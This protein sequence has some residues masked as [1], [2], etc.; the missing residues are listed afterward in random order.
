MRRKQFLTNN[1]IY[2]II[3]S[4]LVLL[5]AIF[6]NKIKEPFQTPI[7]GLTTYTASL[8]VPIRP[9]SCPYIYNLPVVSG[10]PT[11]YTINTTTLHSINNRALGFSVEFDIAHKIF[12]YKNGSVRASFISLMNL[13]K[14]TQNS[15]VGPNI[16]ISGSSS[17]YSA[18]TADRELTVAQ[19][20]TYRFINNFSGSLTM[21]VSLRNNNPSYYARFINEIKTIV[22]NATLQLVEIGNEPEFLPFSTFAEYRT[23]LDSYITALS[24][25]VSTNISIGGFV[26][27][28]PRGGGEVGSDIPF[29]T[30]LVSVIGSYQNTVKVFNM[31]NYAYNECANR[32]NKIG[33]TNRT[34]V[35]QLLDMTYNFNMGT[36][37]DTIKDGTG[38]RVTVEISE[39]NT[40]ACKGHWNVSDSFA[41]ALY[42]IDFVLY[43]LYRGIKRVN[44]HVHPFAD[45]L[46]TPFQFGDIYKNVGNDSDIRI[47]PI[48]YGYW[49]LYYATRNN[50]SLCSPI[51]TPSRNNQIR[52]WTLQNSN[53]YNIVILNMKQSG[54]KK[55]R[56][57]K[58]GRITRN[59]SALYLICKNGISGKDGV[60]LGSLTLDGT[61]NGTPR[62]CSGNT[63]NIVGTSSFTFVNIA[64][65]SNSYY[66]VIVPELTAVLLTV[67][68]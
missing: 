26:H 47:K 21:S 45:G 18:I 66:E 54:N 31:H 46:Y 23:R 59:A 13:L 67:P 5:V 44:L 3:F 35:Y 50:A 39:F 20:N 68:K 27:R 37:V 62:K 2:L 60:F 30:N 52:I 14:T 41:S 32:D 56:I 49:L 10:T 6:Y 63:A 24:P 8:E 25:I 36:D 51:T 19:K 61:T 48:F 42:V 12:A 22:G 55:I 38:S 29:F 4:L 7:W 28:S 17:E 65:V 57:N 33:T 15:S 58:I 40:C 9:L 11:A 43:Q 53:E 16:R 64:L 1:I 34:T